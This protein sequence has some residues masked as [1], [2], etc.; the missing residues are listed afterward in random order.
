MLRVRFN[1][2]ADG[3]RELAGEFI[4][5]S[6]SHFSDPLVRDSPGKDL[7]YPDAETVP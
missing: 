6:G 1:Q 3:S 4:A 5:A 2:M 7:W